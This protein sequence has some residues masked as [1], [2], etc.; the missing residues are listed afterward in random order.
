MLVGKL[1]NTQ[2][3]TIIQNIKSIKSDNYYYK[4]LSAEIIKI[5]EDA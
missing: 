3:K 2:E 5:M 4:K 1:K